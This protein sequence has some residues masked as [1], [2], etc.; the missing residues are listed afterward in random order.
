MKTAIELLVESESLEGES[1]ESERSDCCLLQLRDVVSIGSA[2]KRR[3]VG[4]VE[5]IVEVFGGTAQS[6]CR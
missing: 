6:D 2:R 4:V 5:A 1:D 3:L